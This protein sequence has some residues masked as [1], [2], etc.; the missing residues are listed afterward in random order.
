MFHVSLNFQFKK[1]YIDSNKNKNNNN[2]NNEIKTS[3][4]HRVA[5]HLVAKN[6]TSVV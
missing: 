4:L 5:L 3:I 2:N 6:Y 1:D